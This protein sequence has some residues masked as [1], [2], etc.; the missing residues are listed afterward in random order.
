VAVGDENKRAVPVSVAS[1]LFSRS[2]KLL[3][4][5]FG[6]EFPAPT[7][8]VR[9]SAEWFHRTFPFTS[10]GGIEG[11]LQNTPV[12]LLFWSRT[13]PFWGIFGNRICRI[14]AFQDG[15]LRDGVHVLLVYVGTIKYSQTKVNDFP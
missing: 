9:H 15:W 7:L 2:L 3:N 10:I 12:S 11:D 5:G 13:L 1:C 14:L 6:Q 8:G 4:L